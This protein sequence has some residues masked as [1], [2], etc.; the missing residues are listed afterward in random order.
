MILS[1]Q[2]VSAYA[3]PIQVLTE[4]SG[5]C[6]EG[7]VRTNYQAVFKAAQNQASA[8]HTPHHTTQ[9]A[10]T[11]RTQSQA[12][13]GSLI[14]KTYDASSP[15]KTS[16]R[17][18]ALSLFSSPLQENTCV[19]ARSLAPPGPSWVRLET[20]SVPGSSRVGLVPLHLQSS[21]TAEV[22]MKDS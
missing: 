7:K 20:A 1:G 12:P 6:G 11:I 10:H 3:D 21:I 22:G 15:K 14:S 5:K 4:P 17:P 9:M 19:R 16:L 18:E 13:R 8:H 2:G